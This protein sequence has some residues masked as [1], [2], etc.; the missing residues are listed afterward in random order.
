LFFTKI[1][2]QI[3]DLQ[4]WDDAGDCGCH[5]H[6]FGVYTGRFFWVLIVVTAVLVQWS[7]GLE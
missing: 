4:Q 5:A 7:N 1:Q 2:N 3:I 6:G